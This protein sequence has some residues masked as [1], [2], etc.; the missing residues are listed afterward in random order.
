[1]RDQQPEFCWEK[2]NI[3]L[4]TVK[5]F[6]SYQNFKSLSVLAALFLKQAFWNF[7]KELSRHFPNKQHLLINSILKCQWIW[8][9]HLKI[10]I[11]TFTQVYLGTLHFSFQWLHGHFRRGLQETEVISGADPPHSLWT[12][13]AHHAHCRAQ[14]P[15]RRAWEM[16]SVEWRTHTEGV[17]T[18]SGCGDLQGSFLGK[19]AQVLNAVPVCLS[20]FGNRWDL[21]LQ[22]Q[23]TAM[24]GHDCSHLAHQMS[25]KFFSAKLFGRICTYRLTFASSCKR[26]AAKTDREFQEVPA[27]CFNTEYA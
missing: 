1:M 2:S 10:S 8:N 6:D 20:G 14:K 15:L 5:D 25:I 26:W 4:K 13:R 22:T 21:T 27:H 18:L 9:L 24:L 3:F 16:P 19:H 12:H 11:N 7:L 23:S 17:P